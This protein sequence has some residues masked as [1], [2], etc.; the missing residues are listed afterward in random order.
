MN[1]RISAS[2]FVWSALLGCA[3]FGR[4]AHGQDEITYLDRAAKKEAKVTGSI[5]SENPSQ[6]TLKAGTAGT[7]TIPAND[8]IDVVYEVSPTFRVEYRNAV[9]HENAAD[10]A[11]KEEV[12]KQ[13][14]QEAVKRYEALL[15]GGLPD[16]AKRHIDYKLARM[17][18]VESTP[19]SSGRDAIAALTEFQRNHPQAWQRYRAAHLL[20]ALHV[21]DGSIDAALQTHEDF[22]GTPNLDA[23]LAKDCQLK[24][25]RIL[26]DARRLDAAETKL[27]GLIK[28]DKLDDEHTLRARLLVEE[29]RAGRGKA[30]DAIKN[31]E[32][33]IEKTS[34]AEWKALAFNTLGDCHR[35]ANQP[36]DAMWSYLW[37][38]VVYHANRQEHSRAVY[39]LIQLFREF[40]DDKREKQYREKLAGPVF[41]GL[42]YQRKLLAEK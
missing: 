31:I 25:A 36:R 11:V 20:A 40:K 14:T 34:E 27:K 7:R 39:H 21:R 8:V 12:R 32:Q 35:L 23:E 1:Q 16:N 28:D 6:I 41:A 33:M 3:V 19:A 18:A 10:K 42:D 17:K 4:A 5:Q 38:D 29:C 15:K 30:D 26:V 24:I 13:E 9:S 22:A 2:G 37:V